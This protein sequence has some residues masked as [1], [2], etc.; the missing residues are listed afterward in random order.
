MPSKV[1]LNK[2]IS[3]LLLASRDFRYTRSKAMLGWRFLVFPQPD[4]NSEGG[5][6]ESYLMSLTVAGT[7]PTM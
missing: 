1:Q 4:L 3:G 6:R 5:E 7:D 2:Y